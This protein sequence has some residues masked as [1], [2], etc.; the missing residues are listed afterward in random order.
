M[1]TT[2][3]IAI[4][5]RWYLVGFICKWIIDNNVRYSNNITYINKMIHICCYQYRLATNQL[6]IS[7]KFQL[8]PNG[9]IAYDIHEMLL[10]VA[11]FDSNVSGFFST[12]FYNSQQI[13]PQ[14]EK[15]LNQVL[16]YYK[17]Y[18]IKRLI[19]ISKSMT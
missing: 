4:P 2:I 19:E 13:E 8:Y 10:A 1:A 9:Y 5:N 3:K 15:F 18:G 17:Q 11:K 6:L 7:S 14:I 12:N 16:S